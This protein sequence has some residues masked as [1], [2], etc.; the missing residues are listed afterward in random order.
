MINRCICHNC[1]FLDIQKMKEQG[2]SLEDIIEKTQCGCGCE[3][4]QPYILDS[5]KSGKTEYNGPISKAEKANQ[6]LPK[7]WQPNNE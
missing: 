3:L 6:I 4:C 1:S 5:Y 7:K 2:Q